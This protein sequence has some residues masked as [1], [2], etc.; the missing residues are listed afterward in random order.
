MNKNKYKDKILYLLK[1]DINYFYEIYRNGTQEVYN[2]AIN[3]GLINVI[4]DYIPEKFINK[5]LFDS[6]KHS[7]VLLNTFC[8]KLIYINFLSTNKLLK[9][10]NENNINITYSMYWNIISTRE[11]DNKN[12]NSIKNI[13]N[14][15]TLK[16]YNW[17]CDNYKYKYQ[18][19]LYFNES[20][21]LN[22]QMLIDN[23][24]NIKNKNTIKLIYEKY[25]IPDD[26][27]I[28]ILLHYNCNELYYD[29]LPIK[30]INMIKINNNYS[31]DI[32]TKNIQIELF[33]FDELKK[34]LSSKIN[35]NT[36]ILILLN[37]D[38]NLCNKRF[39]N[40]YSKL[41]ILN[42]NLKCSYPLFLQY[43][44]VRLYKYDIKKLKN[45]KYKTLIKLLKKN[46]LI[47]NETESEL[48]NNIINSLGYVTPLNIEKIK[49]PS[50]ELKN[51][52]YKHY[53]HIIPKTFNPTIEDIIYYFDNNI[54]CCYDKIPKIYKTYNNLIYILKN[55]KYYNI[56]GINHK[57]IKKII[58]DLDIQKEILSINPLFITK[59]HHFYKNYSNYGY[60]RL[61]NQ[62]DILVYCAK[63]CKDGFHLLRILRSELITDEIITAILK[64]DGTVLRLVPYDLIKKKHCNI[65]IK[66]NGL[67]LFYVPYKYLTKKLENKALKSNPNCFKFITN[68]TYKQALCAVKHNGENLLYIKNPDRELCIEAVKQNPEMIRFVNSNYI[69][70]ELAKNVV[71]K[72][73][74][75]IRFIAKPTDD[76]WISA[77]KR[78]GLLLLFCNIQKEEYCI[79]ALKQEP[80]SVFY[81]TTFT[82]A[83]KKVLEEQTPFAYIY[84]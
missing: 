8:H 46:K 28:N 19:E 45:D 75:L 33:T 74:E 1:K 37:L 2:Y 43:E 39:I 54:F 11:I 72:N 49:N 35:Y 38:T 21:L 67:A 4:C 36:A 42:E 84:Y 59:L 29:N 80:K 63:K 68:P 47:K 6:I 48:I 61:I 20:C 31:Y 26:I 69:S 73:C 34:I 14:I 62:I 52:V 22:Y 83:I 82:P 51:T 17:I 15:D 56:Y 60:K 40:E 10:L 24:K 66:Q 16:K 81:I 30:L 77:L 18:S 65:A 12:I 3:N 57:F 70:T 7:E 53:I 27:F 64:I 44:I 5:S 78:N 41:D 23:L 13:E 71:E 50:D 79:E 9:L 58:N 32:C 76:M 25:N 55:I